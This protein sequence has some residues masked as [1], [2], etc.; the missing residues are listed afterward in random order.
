MKRVIALGAPFKVVRHELIT[1]FA[2]TPHARPDVLR[3][4]V[5]LAYPA[6]EEGSKA[7]LGLVR[8]PMHKDDAASFP[9]GRVVRV[10]L[11]PG[12]EGVKLYPY[13]TEEVPDEDAG[14]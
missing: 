1:V 11:R 10:E 2:G 9:V 5:V 12:R 14:R 8:A 7:E 6:D 13:E 3:V 4:N